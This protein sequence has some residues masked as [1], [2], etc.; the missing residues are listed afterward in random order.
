MPRNIIQ[1]LEIDKYRLL[2]LHL[3]ICSSCE[4]GNRYLSMNRINERATLCKSHNLRSK[5]NKLLCSNKIWKHFGFV[6]NC[7]CYYLPF[8]SVSANSIYE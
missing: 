4:H 7:K 6:L 3:P 5:H 2:L 1:K 8:I